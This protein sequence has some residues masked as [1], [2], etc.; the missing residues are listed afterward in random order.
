MGLLLRHC[1]GFFNGIV[2]KSSIRFASK[3]HSRP[4]ER[5]ATAKIVVD[6]L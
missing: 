5:V 4:Q 1:I 2:A 3:L 6:N